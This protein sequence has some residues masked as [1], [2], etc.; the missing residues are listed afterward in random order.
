MTEEMKKDEKTAFLI[1][2]CDAYSDLWE[3]FFHCFFK[4]WPDCPYQIYLSSNFKEFPDKRVKTICIGEDSDYS[5][6]LILILKH[7]KENNLIFW[8]EDVFLA[9]KVDSQRIAS[10]VSKLINNDISYLK[11]SYDY[12]WVY[13]SSL[14]DSI[15]PIPKGVKYRGAVGMAFYN[16]LLLKKMLVPG[17]SAWQMDKSDVS[18]EMEESFYALT[19]KGLKNPPFEYEHAVIK[20]KW[21]Y[22]TPQFLKNEGLGHCISNRQRQS[23]KDHLYVKLFWYRLKMF[24]FFKMHWYEK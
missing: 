24:Q 4:Y 11:L 22:H 3:P 18:N 15:G 1:V 23:L 19:T 16:K 17:Q 9:G 5:T 13:S 12:P 2:S 21:C 10:L 6:N 8:F 14:I 7:I 20:G